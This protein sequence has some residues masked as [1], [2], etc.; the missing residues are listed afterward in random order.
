MFR[1]I[2]DPCLAPPRKDEKIWVGK[3]GTC[4]AAVNRIGIKIKPAVQV[5]VVYLYGT[6]LSGIICRGLAEL[7]TPQIP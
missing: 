4:I 7:F 5:T 2:K 1:V 3:W 6:V